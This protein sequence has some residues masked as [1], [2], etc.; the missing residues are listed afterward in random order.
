MKKSVL[1]IQGVS[2]YGGALESLY[3]LVT[4]LNTYR[5]VV[6]TSGKG[7]LTRRLKS[8]GVTYSLVKMGMWRKVKSWPGLPY[9][10]YR[11][12]QMS[13]VQGVSIIHCN[14]LWDTPY[15][16]V[17]GRFLK[18]PVVT[19]VRNTFSKDKIR[20]YWLHRVNVVISVSKAVVHPLL[21]TK[22]RCE[23]I[24]NGVDLDLFDNTIFCKEVA[25]RE[26]G[27]GGKELVILL[28]GRVDSTKGQREAILAMAEVVR[29]CTQ[30]ILVIVGE[31]SRQERHLQIELKQLIREL[32]LEDRVIFTGATRDMPRFMAASDLVIMPSLQSSREG[33]GRVLIEAMAMG[34]PVIA[35]E[36]GGVPEVV[37][38]GDTG[39]LSPPGDVK[40]LAHAIEALLKDG[41]MR[42]EMGE[43]GY[44]RVKELFDLRRTVEKVED[45]YDGLL[46]V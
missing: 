24:Y 38:D 15:G 36:T 29:N 27:L 32:G 44:R 20:K 45:L 7:E 6:V 9:V 23:V 8:A 19:H 41:G 37:E 16:V 42:K 1:Y 34:R 21:D 40:A 33:F 14:T 5:P 13:K 17:L 10:F 30:A 35:S 3:Q 2:R 4:H 43:R 11:L 22:V 28:P 12:Y 46:H 25:K 18:V 26:A 39:L 31:T